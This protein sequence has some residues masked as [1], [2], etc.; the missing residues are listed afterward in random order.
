MTNEKKLATARQR[1]AL[2]GGVMSGLKCLIVIAGF[3]LV[4]AIGIGMASLCSDFL[5]EKLG[6][7]VGT[8]GSVVIIFFCVGVV[9]HYYEYD[10]EG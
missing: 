9:E 2:H 8:S 4:V 1:Y 10:K 3:A 5:G 7:I 6:I